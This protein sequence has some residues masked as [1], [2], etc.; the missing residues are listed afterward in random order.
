LYAAD[1][2]AESLESEQARD[3]VTLRVVDFGSSWGSVL[4]RFVTIH[5]FTHL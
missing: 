1:D 2:P 5:E 4:P 3:Q